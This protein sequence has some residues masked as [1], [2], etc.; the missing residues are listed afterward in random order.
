M[1]VGSSNSVRHDA[2]PKGQVVT[3]ARE[4]VA[5]LREGHPEVL[6]VGYFGSYARDDYVPGSDLDVLI[7]LSASDKDKWVDRV[8]DY[9]PSGFP[10]A[11]DVFPYTSAELDRMRRDRAAFLDAIL[12]EIVW[13]P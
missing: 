6:R 1:P 5:R 4:W 2:A 11:V 3:A 8:A 9:R 12:G 10:V 13:L 7:E